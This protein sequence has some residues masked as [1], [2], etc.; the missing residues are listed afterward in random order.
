VTAINR[1]DTHKGLWNTANGY[2]DRCVNTDGSVNKL[3]DTSTNILFALGVIDLKSSRANSHISK[4]ETDLSKDT[5]GFP[6]Y[7]GDTFYL[8]HNGVPAA[9]RRQRHLHHGRR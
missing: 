2:Y 9:T 6:R 8:L 3:E 4:L 1:D 7:S 5:Y